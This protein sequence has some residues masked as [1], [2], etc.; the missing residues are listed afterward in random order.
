MKKRWISC[1]SLLL[2]L[3]VFVSCNNGGGDKATGTQETPIKPA[4]PENELLLI[5]NGQAYCGI[6]RQKGL[7]KEPMTLC[8]TLAD[9]I[10]QKTGVAVEA[11]AD[12]KQLS[13][14]LV[15]ILIGDTNRSESKQA[16]EK[17]GD[18]EYSV[19]VINGKVVVVGSDDVML[20]K[21]IQYFC[22][23]VGKDNWTI[24][25]NYEQKRDGSEEY[26]FHEYFGKDVDFTVKHEQVKKMS[27]A[28]ATAPSGQELSCV[29]GGCTDGTYTYACML[30]ST[31]DDPS[32][33]ILKYDLK[34]QN[35]V[36]VSKELKLG[37]ANDMVYNPDDNVLVVAHCKAETSY[38]GQSVKGIVSIFD[39]DTLA[40]KETIGLKA[41]CDVSITYDRVHK[42]YIT[43][44]V[45]NNY[46][47]V[48]DRDFNLVRTITSFGVLKGQY[49][50]EH[51]MQGI[52]TDGKYLY[53]F[54]W[55][56]GSEFYPTY[57]SIED[58]ISTRM[59]VFDLSTGKLIETIELGIKREIENVGLIGKKLYIWANNFSWTGAE[60]YIAEITPKV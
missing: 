49:A 17:L 50:G 1:L 30:N 40:L 52:E 5:A 11:I 12:T 3:L 19:S 41:G 51:L 7:S 6:V 36:A 24:L 58:E 2:C 16:K 14:G 46:V 15:E 28:T 20:G 18:F 35:R 13:D 8:S 32:C 23:L 48:Y 44:G 29:Q 21:A 37:H 10:Q 54:D 53:I 60:F 43:I 57:K 55:H 47:Y 39:P 25:K 26:L 38:N 27:I 33:M 42:Q 45:Q 22:T 4:V 34:T 59:H 56:G 31:E 9:T